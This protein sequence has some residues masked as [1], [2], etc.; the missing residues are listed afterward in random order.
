MPG[1]LRV[2]PSCLAA[3]RCQEAFILKT[4][5]SKE[6]ILW[7]L[8]WVGQFLRCWHSIVML[9]LCSGFAWSLLKD[10]DI[11]LNISLIEKVA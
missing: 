6:L 7:N 8:P 4:K 9:A 11:V 10:F 5:P 2:K 3:R 1:F